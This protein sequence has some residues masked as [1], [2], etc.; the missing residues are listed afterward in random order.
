MKFLF[1]GIYDTNTVSLAPQLLRAWLASRPELSGAEFVAM[2]FSIFSHDAASIARVIEAQGGDVVAFSAYI[3]NIGIILEAAPKLSA[4]VILGG[5]QV[6]GIEGELLAANPAVD[7]VVTGEGEKTCAQLAQAIV[8]GTSPAAVPGVTTRWGFTPRVGEPMNLEDIPRFYA[9]V[10]ACHPG[11]EWIAFE[12][13]RGCASACRYCTWAD[14]RKLRFYPMERVLAELDVI[15]AQPSLRNIYFCDSSLLFNKRRAKIILNH[16]LESGAD[17]SIRFEFNAEH[18]D[19]E[20]IELMGRLPDMEFN[21]GLQTVNPEALRCIGRSFNRAKFEENYRKVAARVGE[22]SVTLDLIYGLPGDDFKGYRDSVRY[23]LSLGRP[24]RILTNPLILLPGSHFF[25]HREDYGIG[26]KDMRGYMV[27]HTTT[28]SRRD[29]DLA[30]RLSLYVAT[31]F[32]NDRLLDALRAFSESSGRDLVDVMTSFFESL[33]FPLAGD[34]PD[35]IPTVA[36]GFKQRNVVML[37]II[38]N[39]DA[40]VEGFRSY[41]G[42]AVDHLLEDYQKGYTGQY[43]KLKRFASQ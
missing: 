39:F 25:Q 30:R 16:I 5:P 10:F 17:K 40:I 18:L 14:S 36:E 21:F 37:R 7:M 43:H 24:K 8:N 11:L 4:T 27:E 22:S 9:D 2:E 29:M 26:L 38:E 20:T 41:S 32:L 31:A 3:W 15:L 42:H 33:P 6:T 23:A 13:S 34:C 35:M 28:F 1:V 19:D 12:T